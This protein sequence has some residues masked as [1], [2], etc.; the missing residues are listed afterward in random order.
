MDAPSDDLLI[1]QFESCLTDSNLGVDD[2][3][4]L[5]ASISRLSASCAPHSRF[6]RVTM[7]SNRHLV[8]DWQ[9]LYEVTV[10]SN[11]K[12]GLLLVKKALNPLG[13]RL[14]K[15]E[16]RIHRALQHPLIVII[17]EGDS[18]ANPTQQ[19]MIVTN[20]LENDSL[21]GH[22]PSAK[23]AE[24]CQLTGET[25]IARIIVGIA[26]AMRYLHSQGIMH[27]DLQPANILLD[28]DWNIRLSNFHF[29]RRCHGQTT[30][31]ER[32]NSFPCLDSHYFAPE[33]AETGS[34]LASDVFSFGL[35]L[36]EL[37]AGRS[38]FPQ[39][40]TK[41]AIIK[42]QLKGQEPSPIPNFVLPH[43]AELIL[44]C[45]S[46]VVAERPTFDDIVRRFDEMDFKIT[47][48]VKSR[49]V[50]AFLDHIEAQEKDPLLFPDDTSSVPS[51]NLND[52]T[53]SIAT[54]QSSAALD[55]DPNIS[56]VPTDFGELQEPGAPDLLRE[57]MPLIGNSWPS[58]V[59]PIP[60]PPEPL[61]SMALPRA[62]LFPARFRATSILTP[63]CR[64]S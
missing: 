58:I 39:N 44:E 32:A 55:S 57:Q 17:Q 47:A 43:T 26:L 11:G 9:P 40:I 23:G 62:A 33:C 7:A 56:R 28:K 15:C 46:F 19:T 5:R 3:P 10:A 25:R 54:N 21:S 24:L 37:V 18:I 60:G 4:E 31:A 36:F 50:R 14:L 49:K 29:S 38:P 45:W 2:F 52:E 48:N 51:G 64:Y 61:D 1:G 59:Q 35:I 41:L 12:G 13:S 30:V 20:V 42:N 63:T 34:C 16:L 6:T 8:P 53:L 27:G 22:L